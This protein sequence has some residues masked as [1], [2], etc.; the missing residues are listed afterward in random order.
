MR[1]LRGMEQIFCVRI[2]KDGMTLSIMPL[3]EAALAQ[4]CQLFWIQHDLA[5]LAIGGHEENI[6][7]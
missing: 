1:D 6:A 4:P 2:G 3:F 7:L 5:F